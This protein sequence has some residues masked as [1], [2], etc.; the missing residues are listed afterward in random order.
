MPERV[1]GNLAIHSWVKKLNNTVTNDS[2]PRGGRH[3]FNLFARTSVVAGENRQGT[4]LPSRISIKVCSYPQVILDRLNR[5]CC[6]AHDSLFV[7]LPDD[8]CKLLIPVHI[9][10]SKFA[11]LVDTEAGI[12]KG[13]Q[14]GPITVC[15]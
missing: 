9:A 11:G 10:A 1:R 6:K 2:S 12:G 13:Q 4:E 5:P 8:N 3:W 7:A 15:A 14:E